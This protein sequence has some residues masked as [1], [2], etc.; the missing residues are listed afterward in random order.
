MAGH[1]RIVGVTHFLV[2]S[3]REQ[4]TGGRTRGALLVTPQLHRQT[5]GG[6]TPIQSDLGIRR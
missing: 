5:Y 4:A 3:C 2:E 6:G 1:K